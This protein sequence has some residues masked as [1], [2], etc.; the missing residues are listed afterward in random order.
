MSLFR[1]LHLH[2][3]KIRIVYWGSF[4]LFM[5]FVALPM[6]F[7]FYLFDENKARQII[8]KQFNNQNYTIKVGS[9][10]RAL[11]H[12][13]NLNIDNLV[14]SSQSNNQTLIQVANANCSLS[15]LSLALGK[16]KVGS[17]NIDGFTINTNNFKQYDI[18]NLLNVQ[19]LNASAFNSINNI[20]IN[21]IVTKNAQDLKI[22][23]KGSL[24][25]RRNFSSLNFNFNF[26]IESQDVFVSIQGRANPNI[27]NNMLKLESFVTQVYNKQNKASLRAKT[28]SYDIKN[29]IFAT[30]EIS[31]KLN[32]NNQSGEINASSLNWSNNGINI[33]N[34]TSNINDH[35]ALNPTYSKLKVNNLYIS[36]ALDQLN[37]DN[38]QLNHSTFFKKNSLSIN[39]T[40]QGLAIHH[41]FT[42][43]TTSCFNQIKLLEPSKNIPI[44]NANL[45][46]N[47]YY[48]P[49]KSLIHLNFL[50]D[51][52]SAPLNLDLQIFTN[53]KKPL[54]KANGR[55]D[56]IDLSR[57]NNNSEVKW[58]P[59]Y[60]DTK[61]LPFDWISL[62]DMEANL[63]IK[64]FA[65]DRIK[66]TNVTTQ[67]NMY[68]NTLNVNSIKA[69]VYQGILD[70]SIKITQKPDKSYDL[71]AKQVFKNLKLQNVFDDIFNVKAITG[72][73]NVN[74]DIFAKNV[75]SYNDLHTKLNGKIE[76]S[77]S[78]GQFQG[79]NLDL[80]ASPTEFD[81]SAKKS[82]IFN[83]LTS[84]FNFVNG[85]SNNGTINFTSDY[86]K[87]NGKGLIDFITNKIDYKLEIKS[88]LPT[89]SQKI[90]SVLIP[91]VVTGEL[92]TP[93]INIENIQLYSKKIL[94]RVIEKKR[95]RNLKHHTQALK[96]VP[97]LNVRHH[98]S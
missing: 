79:I 44:I 71:N 61:S 8:I 98:H 81:F 69:D 82:T 14:I 74:L 27:D 42:I 75:Y 13:L 30:G 43:N 83:E 15:W 38:L 73:A 37:I 1:H 16:Y 62:L 77:A 46:G 32:I 29:M 20:S 7:F 58:L 63:S 84:N 11:W 6:F 85:I 93:K 59:L 66:L 57:F 50:G 48:D 90:S 68:N 10:K 78:H 47:C 5:I 17:L 96:K 18:Q 92:F 25:I 56:K 65:F 12:G 24:I 3:N 94:P 33:N 88:I 64:Y 39:S 51:V 95:F 89:N 87:A 52:N 70:G 97:H 54:V 91:V 9:I 36:S 76:I 67:F 26:D 21:N 35:K 22:L 49:K 40:V 60:N 28:A 41:D 19:Q 53:N 72:N 4:I 86:V 55:L 2:K 31:G 80:F 34:I 23:H 45:N